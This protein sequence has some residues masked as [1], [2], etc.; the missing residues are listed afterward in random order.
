VERGLVGEG[1]R[2][3]QLPFTGEEADIGE[4]ADVPDVGRADERRRH[5]DDGRRG[6]AH[7]QHRL[8]GQPEQ[9]R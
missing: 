1:G 8:D 7:P 9:R 4:E 6:G 5:R 2:H 3:R